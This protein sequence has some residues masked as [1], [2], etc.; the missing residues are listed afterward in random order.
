MCPATHIGLYTQHIFSSTRSPK[1]WN[2]RLVSIE[3]GCVRFYKF[4]DQTMCIHCILTIVLDL[5]LPFLSN[6]TC[7]VQF[8]SNFVSML[9]TKRGKESSKG[10]AIPLCNFLL[11]L[12]LIMW[13]GLYYCEA[14]WCLKLLRMCGF[15]VIFVA[16]VANSTFRD[17]VA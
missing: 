4:F 7:L 12:C 15:V 10:L 3:M 11:V 13:L 17:N 9:D 8:V 2:I 6:S 5:V 14:W 1:A 16:L